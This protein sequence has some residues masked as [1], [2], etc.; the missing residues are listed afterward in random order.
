[1][2]LA[3]AVVAT[4]TVVP[5]ASSPALPGIGP[6]LPERQHLRPLSLLFR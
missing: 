4:S 2:A 3:I 1:V 6:R 5:R